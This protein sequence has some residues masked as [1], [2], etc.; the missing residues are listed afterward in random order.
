MDWGRISKLPSFTGVHTAVTYVKSYIDRQETAD[1]A[2]SLI[3]TRSCWCLSVQRG[4]MPWLTLAFEQLVTR[5]TC[6]RVEPLAKKP[7]SK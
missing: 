1:Y 3:V 6:F 2:C 5:I 7:K 4:T